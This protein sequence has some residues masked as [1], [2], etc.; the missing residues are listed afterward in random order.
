MNKSEDILIYIIT[1]TYNRENLIHR[2]IESIISQ[3][4]KNWKL[5][6]VDDGS[7]DNT[8]EIL[9][10]YLKKFGDK[11]IYKYQE[12]SG[13][14]SARNIGIE[15][16]LKSNYK[17]DDLI[18][19]LDSDDALLSGAFDFV[20]GKKKENPKIK[21]F[22]FSYEND[23][24]KRTTILKESEMI[25][26]FKEI[27]SK[28]YV[29]ND[30]LNFFQVAIF[31]DYKLR[32]NEKINGGECL[33]FWNIYKKYKTLFSD[34]ILAIYY[35]DAENSLIRSSLTLKKISNIRD[36]N[37]KIFESFEVDLLEINKKYLGEIY[38]VSARAEVLLGRK[39]KSF[40]YFLKGISIN[41]LDFKRIFIYLISFFDKKLLI[42]NFLIK[43]FLRP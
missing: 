12:N 43:K 42:N 27:V 34:K 40:E 25:L 13:S 37:N 19:F 20:L 39:K 14:G 18:L 41:P 23:S 33:L 4:Y 36:L 1:P 5:I 9:E 3:K 11:I 2:P 35:Q 32:Y 15:L 10:P 21:S 8:K 17:E 6:I 16:V 30:T 28:K 7:T 22:A 24:G 29:K 31:K 26:G 38:F